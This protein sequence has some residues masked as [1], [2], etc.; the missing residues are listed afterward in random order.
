MNVSGRVDAA[1][2]N[3]ADKFELHYRQQLSALVD[4]ELPTDEARFLLRRLQHD[5]ELSGCQER[6]QLL[7]DVLR[8]QACAPAPAG[9]DL[10]IR[11]AIEAGA[12]Q[13]S[14]ASERQV[15]RGGWR[16]WGGGA[17]LAASVA[18]VALFMARGQLPGPAVPETV[19]A[20]AAQVPAATVVADADPAAGAGTEAGT[21]AGLAA[22]AP[23]VAAVALR[24]ADASVRRGSAT[25]TQQAARS[26]AAR[27]AEPARAVAAQAPPPALRRDP[28]ADP[29]G[30]LQARPWPRSSLSPALSG[31]ALNASAPTEGGATFYPFEPRLPSQGGQ[32]APDAQPARP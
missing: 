17:A 3:A 32:A 25:R 23:A 28:F 30:V 2:G 27:Q 31:T 22:A 18:A 29:G 20:T 8:G 12:G 13:A 26:V 21:E 14:P 6:W 11:A 19:I 1:A 15:R 4:G 5:G 7:G 10:R 9:F 24:R 16:R